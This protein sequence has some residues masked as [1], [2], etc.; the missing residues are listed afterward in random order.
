M[1]PERRYL[2][3]TWKL[4]HWYRTKMIKDC[5]DHDPEHVRCNRCDYADLWSKQTDALKTFLED[6]L[7]ITIGPDGDYLST[8]EVLKD[9]DPEDALDLDDGA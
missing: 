5:N 2:L 4:K 3:L 7:D 6:E 9:I 8:D 1:T